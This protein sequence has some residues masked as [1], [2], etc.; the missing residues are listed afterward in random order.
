MNVASAQNSFRLTHS[1]VT[2]VF[3]VSVYVVTTKVSCI[4]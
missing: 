4:F 3:I 1:M 2:L